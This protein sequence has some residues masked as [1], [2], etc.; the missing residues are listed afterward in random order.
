MTDNG[1]QSSFISEN[2]LFWGRYK[3]SGLVF[4]KGGRKDKNHMTQ[5][6]AMDEK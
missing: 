2:G 5:S 1:Y 4:L 6:C 3:M